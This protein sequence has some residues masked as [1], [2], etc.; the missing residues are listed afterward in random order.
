[1]P[2][3]DGEPGGGE[4]ASAATSAPA[5]AAYASATVAA[6][7]S[8]ARLL[9]WAAVA[10]GNPAVGSSSRETSWRLDKS[11]AAAANGARQAGGRSVLFFQPSRSLSDI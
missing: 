8:P 3:A 7:L 5:V 6:T 11:P 10:C 9:Y 4:C 2:H 1:M